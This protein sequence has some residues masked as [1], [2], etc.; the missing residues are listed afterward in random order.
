MYKGMRVSFDLNVL[1]KCF[2]SLC[3]YV[4]FI[5]HLSIIEPDTQSSS[6]YNCSVAIKICYCMR[7][8]NYGVT[9][10]ASFYACT[11]TVYGPT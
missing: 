9:S 3:L 10:S 11:H 1:S 5:L 8:Y 7:I 4:S 2:L 6:Q